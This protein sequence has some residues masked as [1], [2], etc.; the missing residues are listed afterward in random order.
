MD[1]GLSNLGFW[2][3]S[4][5]ALF[6]L[7]QGFLIRVENDYLTEFERPGI[8]LRNRWRSTILGGLGYLV[9]GWCSRES[10]PFT[11]LI[12]FGLATAGLIG[13]W[14][15]DYQLLLIPDRFQILGLLSG[16]GFTA[17]LLLSGEHVSVV[18]TEIGFGLFLV[19]VLW[20][21]SAIYFRIRG[22]IGFGFGD[23]KLLAWLSLFV[24]KRMPDLVVTSVA[25]GLTMLIF[26]TARTSIKARA[27]TLPG[28]QDAF[29]F[30]P[31]IVLGF[32]IEGIAHNG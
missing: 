9:L 32:F 12:F 4:G 24:G 21:M 20:I 30:G 14:R 28:G 18:F 16:L 5:L 1:S 17:T 13:I 31:A 2:L 10:L 3:A 15:V 27:L 29:A 22:T 25:I 8:S 7:A 26:N 11:S 6:L 23:I 19:G